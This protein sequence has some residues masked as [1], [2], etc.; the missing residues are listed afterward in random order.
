MSLDKF[1]APGFDTYITPQRTMKA[2][3]TVEPFQEEDI[4]NPTFVFTRGKSGRINLPGGRVEKGETDKKAFIREIKEELGIDLEE[5]DIPN[6]LFDHTGEVADGKLA[7]WV[8]RHIEIASDL[9]LQ[10]TDGE[11]EALRATLDQLTDPRERYLEAMSAMAL[12]SLNKF[13]DLPNYTR[14]SRN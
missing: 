6:E 8:L 7:E 11:T 3:V 1:Y 4:D 9:P 5:E 2:I 14:N 13:L 10:C 12:F